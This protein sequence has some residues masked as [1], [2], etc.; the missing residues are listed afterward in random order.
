MNR[1]RFLA[2]VFGVL[3]LGVIVVATH[4]MGEAGKDAKDKDLRSSGLMKPIH[5]DRQ[6]EMTLN[7]CRFT[8]RPLIAYTTQQG[9]K[10][11]ALQVQPKLAQGPER[12]RDILLLID[13]SASQAAA[14]METSRKLAKLFADNLRDNDRLSLW[15]ISNEARAVSRGFQGKKDLTEALKTLDKEYASGGTNLKKGLQDVIPTFEDIAGRQKVIVFVGDGLSIAGP[16][17]SSDRASLVK[18]MAR[19]EIGFYPIPIGPRLDPANLHGL[20]S[21]TGGLVMRLLP[22]DWVEDVFKR[23]QASFAV[24]VLYHPVLRLPEAV[25]EVYPT[26]LPPLRSDIPTLVV[27]KIGAAKE[28]AFRVSGALQG[29]DTS[30][31]IKEA[32]PEG[33]SE[34]YFLIQV[35][36]QWKNRKETPA[37]IQGD[38]ALAF[39]AEQN[40][41][42]V[43]NLKDKAE[44]AIQ[45]DM[46]DAASK[47]FQQVL[48]IDPLDAEA[49]NGRGFVQKMRD[50]QLN[51]DQIK[52]KMLLKKGDTVVRLGAQGK[53]FSVP[54]GQLPAEDKG[55][56]KLP[57]PDINNDDI[58]KE[59][60]ARQVVEGQRVTRQIEDAIRRANRMVSS[61]PTDAVEVIKQELANLLGNTDVSPEIQNQ[62]SGRLTRA[63]QAV[64]LEGRKAKRDEDE[65][66]QIQAMADSRGAQAKV[67]QNQDDRNRERMRLFHHLMTQAKEQEA[68]KRTEEIRR[69]MVNLGLPVPQA[70]TA[71]YNFAQR[72]YYLR[73]LRDLQRV[74]D[75]KW[76]AVLFET[77]RSHVPFPD[78]PPV[79]YPK[80]T[81]FALGHLSRF[82]DWAE[83]SNYRKVKYDAAGFGGPDILPRTLELKSLL[84]KQVRYQGLKDGDFKLSEV[85]DQLRNAYNLEFDVNEKAFAGDGV[86]DVMN[87][88]IASADKPLPPINGSI[89]TVLKK[90]VARIPAGSTGTFLLRRESIEITTGNA[91]LAEKVVRVYPVGDLIYPPPNAFNQQQGLQAATLFGY[92]G[93]Y[94]FAGQSVANQ[95][96]GA[97]QGAGQIG[98]IGGLGGLGGGGLGGGLGGGGGMFGGVNQM[99]GNAGAGAIGGFAMQ[100]GGMN[101]GNT[102]GSGPQGQFGNVGAQF[103][104][105]GG[106]YSDYLIGIIRNV[107]GN[108]DKD[109][110]AAI[111]P[112][113]GPPADAL[114][115]PSAGPEKNQIGYYQPADALV[116]KGTSRVHTNPYAPIINVGGEAPAMGAANRQGNDRL[117]NNRNPGKGQPVLAVANK[118]DE[119]KLKADPDAYWKEILDNGGENPYMV[120]ATADFLA[121]NGF[122]DRAA[123][124]LKANLRK[125]VVV[126]PWVYESLAIALR[127]SGASP[128][129]IERAEVAAIDLEPSNGAGF[130]K[131]GKSLA[132]MKRY[133]M[134]LAFCKQAAHLEPGTPDPFLAAL[135][136]A[137]LAEDATAMEWAAGNLLG[138]DWTNRN[139]EIQE[140]AQVKIDAL[141][142]K[143]RQAGNPEGPKVADNAKTKTHRDLVIRLAWQGD[144]DLDLVVREPVGSVCSVTNSQSIG[145]G[146][147]MG[148]S[149]RETGLETYTASE[150]FK[151]KYE[152]SV[153]KVWGQ[154]L[155]NKAQVRVIR[156]FGAPEQNEELLTFDLS[157]SK[158]L[159]IQLE[160]GRRMETAYVPPPS[161]R[162]NNLG[163]MEVVSSRDLLTQLRDMA[164]PEI[165]GIQRGAGAAATIPVESAPTM[166]S[167]K[168]NG[169]DQVIYQTRVQSFMKNALDM[170][171]QVSLA[172]DRRSVRVSLNPVYN[173]N[174]RQGPVVVS[175]SV[176]P[177]D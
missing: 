50:G 16:I 45:E 150:A 103:G 67:T 154:T 175:S 104:Q 58:L 130:L 61:K 93:S 170:T 70:V 13:T 161:L 112:P 86:M 119:A 24:P 83:L 153:K 42:A 149:L 96:L 121:M 116:I 143:F 60:K 88:V 12:P 158:P 163:E 39:A 49:K 108:G 75:D 98:A 171:A 15:T 53:R 148:D 152:I 37:L 90:I 134:A 48:E 78:E 166:A 23:L 167:K 131:A 156:N 71:G 177:G 28:L 142:R 74:R 56:G 41:I 102:G 33:E 26:Q 136:Y 68:Q 1:N 106:N 135:D 8:G 146:I 64:T 140:R 117:A 22:G 144:A 38:R 19:K 113:G 14:P 115:D 3:G 63:L 55:K 147:L 66:L 32:M 51:R 62:L 21:G 176:I 36:N 141:A 91:A 124:F 168:G 95:G 162:Q 20:A 100:G 137:E 105:Q 30:L 43:N 76:L 101:F 57:P 59:Q 69:D 159:A 29:Q 79:I 122:F 73:E 65:R 111:P 132:G 97:L 173:P 151:G 44:W 46:F 169:D 72:S 110:A 123:G 107:V 120:I 126:K 47:L 31:E 133:P 92:A 2:G 118:I 125:G 11:F 139:R 6:F 114:G 94:G 4:V 145:G 128:A 129:E 77:E 34:N 172:A 165:T 164:N 35:V 160:N 85:M 18:E 157:K 80:D 87:T 127:E 155:G 81:D 89:S 54:V 99:G 25:T 84:L 138:Q 82:K 27:G 17:N 9:E 109:W 174:S 40:Q 7:Q 52:N 5:Q 10:Y